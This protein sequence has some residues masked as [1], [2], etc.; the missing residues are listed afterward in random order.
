M[1]LRSHQVIAGHPAREMRR[2]LREIRHLQVACGY[3]CD[4]LGCSMKEAKE[5]ME[6]L[7][8]EGYLSKNGQLDGQQL[9][10]TTVSGNQLAGANLRPISRV[11]AE[12]KLRGFMERVHA[13]NSNPDYLETI[14]GVIVFGSLLSEK[15]KLGTW[16]WAF[17]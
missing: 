12:K 1:I 10:E 7:E 5:V 11:T 13:A 4:V 6:A 8:Q 3:V 15:E 14:T 9:Y 2:L 17:G 16:M